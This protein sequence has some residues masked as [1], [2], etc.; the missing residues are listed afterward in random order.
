[1][2]TEKQIPPGARPASFAMIRTLGGIAMLSGFLVVLVYQITLPII[3]ENLRLALERA[4]FKV[5]PGAVSRVNFILSPEGMVRADDSAGGGPVQGEK[6]YA[7]YD[8][9]GRLAGVAMEAAAPGYQDVVRTLYGYSPKCECIVGITVLQST[10]TPG[11][12][13][14]VETDPGFLANFEALDARLN[15]AK[16]ALAHPIRTVKHGTKT[17]PW[18]IDAISGATVTSKA[19][20]KGLN[21]SAQAKLPF[22]IKYLDVLTSDSE[23]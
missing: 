8:E 18:Q 13:D 20:G 14:K 1:M 23:Q 12:G 19:I 10:E 16:T 4:V 9:S 7:G 2:S 22:L 6:I 15:A 21:N 3:T 5:I 11:L 17:N